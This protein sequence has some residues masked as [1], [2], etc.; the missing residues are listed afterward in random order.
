M[1]SRIFSGLILAGLLAADPAVAGDDGI[2]GTWIRGDGAAHVRIAPCGTE[3]CATNLWIKDPQKQNE[4]IG[5]RL[6]FKIAPNGDEWAG[7]A[8]DP[9]RRLSLSARL[10]VL[11][12]D[13]MMSSGCVLGGLLCRATQWTRM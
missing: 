2:F 10:K 13:R 11:A 6:I 12:R 1:D 7:S 8:Y 5:D 9:Q 3:I 4:R